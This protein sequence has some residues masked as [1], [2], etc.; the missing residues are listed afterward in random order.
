M[1]SGSRAGGDLPPGVPPLVGRYPSSEGTGD[2]WDQN[3]VIRPTSLH[4][5][6]TGAPKC[7]VAI[8]AGASLSPK[9]SATANLCG[10]LYPSP[11]RNHSHCHHKR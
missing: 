10:P 4:T 5:Y 2:S 11:L 3:P 1:G 6:R 8:Q 7:S 9:D